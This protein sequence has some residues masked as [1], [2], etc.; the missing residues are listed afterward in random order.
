MLESTEAAV[1]GDTLTAEAWMEVLLAAAREVATTALGLTVSERLGEAA[2]LTSGLEGAYLALVGQ[3]DSIQIGIASSPEGC[4][5]LAKA[6]L[7]MTS[8]DD[9]PDSDMADALCEI[10]NIL[11]GVVKR[12]VVARAASM[13]LGLPLFVKGVVQPTERIV[14]TL[15]DVCIGEVH[16]IL[17]LIRPR[18]RDGA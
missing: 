5:A 14:L 8:D 4:A 13:T 10:V 17:V 18:C 9:L 6:L 15:T 2:T 7:G 1:P 12:N 3:E 16:A 11:A